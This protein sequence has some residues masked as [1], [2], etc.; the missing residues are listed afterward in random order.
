MAQARF[1]VDNGKE[2]CF[3]KPALSGAATPRRD[4]ICHG[5]ARNNRPGCRRAP[6]QIVQ[7]DC[8]YN[9]WLAQLHAALGRRPQLGRT[10]RRPRAH[11]TPSHLAALRDHARQLGAV[12]GARRDGLDL[13]YHEQP[14]AQHAAEDDVLA[15]QPVALLAGD[16][17]LAA[18]VCVWGREGCVQGC[19]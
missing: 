6:V 3:M 19:V 10:R 2:G 18:C 8:G 12:G 14:V 1:E 17:E 13:A 9:D 4:A 7:E 15:V 5:H 11:S 16:E